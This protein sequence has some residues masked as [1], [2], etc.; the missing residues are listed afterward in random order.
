VTL[1][2]CYGTLWVVVLLLSAIL[3]IMKSTFD[4]SEC[5]IIWWNL[6][7]NSTFSTRWQSHDQVWTFLK[8]K[9]ADG[10]HFKN[11]FFT[12]TRQLIVIS[13]KFCIVK[14]NNMAMEVTWHKLLNFKNSTLRTATIL[15]IVKSPYLNEKS[16]NFVAL[17]CVTLMFSLCK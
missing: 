2:T 3:K 12:I 9:M 17:T 15:H 8:F 13:V 10:R 4:I 5:K 11:L 7:H 6:I 1:W 16:S 14:W